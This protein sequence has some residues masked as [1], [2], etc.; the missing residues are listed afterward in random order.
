M[1]KEKIIPKIKPKPEQEKKQRTWMEIIKGL[2][3]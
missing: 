2:F 1:D 3:K